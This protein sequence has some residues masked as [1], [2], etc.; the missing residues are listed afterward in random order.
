MKKNYGGYTI[1][2]NGKSMILTASRVAYALH[3]GT[4]PAELDVLHKCDNPPCCNPAHLFL[5]TNGDNILDRVKKGRSVKGDDHW[6]HRRPEQTTKG[7]RHGQSKLTDADVVT[8]RTQHMQGVTRKA[9]AEQFQVTIATIG[10]IV[11]RKT[12]KHL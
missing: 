9:I 4:D 7:Q 6:T 5:G 3:Y 8:I 12:W 1:I 2:R 11:T 10:L